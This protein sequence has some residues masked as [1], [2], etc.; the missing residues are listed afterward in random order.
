M[1]KTKLTSKISF[2]ILNPF[3]IVFCINIV[4]IIMS[5]NIAVEYEQDL[6]QKS[7]E[8]SSM[9]ARVVHDES[10]IIYGVLAFNSQNKKGFKLN[11]AA[12]KDDHDENMV[13]LKRH[14][15]EDTGDFFRFHSILIRI[16]TIVCSQIFLTSTYLLIYYK[17]F[18]RKRL[19]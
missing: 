4:C 11:T 17:I 1:S 12:L 9:I 7:V 8:S 16:M 14:A 10:D 13:K 5:I 2:I 6:R 15:E 3:Y 18:V 19:R